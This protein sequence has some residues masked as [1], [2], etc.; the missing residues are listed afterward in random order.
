MP[1]VKESS[2][3][4]ILS[5]GNK[6]HNKANNVLENDKLRLILTAILSCLAVVFTMSLMWPI[7]DFTSLIYAVALIIFVFVIVIFITKYLFTNIALFVAKASQPFAD[8][9]KQMNE[10]RKSNSSKVLGMGPKAEVGIKYF[11][12]QEKDKS[13]YCAKYIGPM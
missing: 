9:Y 6:I 7:C 2:M 5:A 13:V 11:I 10:K 8:S 4:K 12:E 1:K 3:M